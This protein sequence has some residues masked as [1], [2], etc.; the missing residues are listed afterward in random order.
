[1]KFLLGV[2]VLSIIPFAAV[3]QSTPISDRV[4]VYVNRLMRDI[5]ESYYAFDT[6]DSGFNHAIPSGLFASRTSLLKEGFIVGA[7]VFDSNAADGCS[8]SP[9]AFDKGGAMLKL[10]VP[11]LPQV[12]DY[13]GLNFEEPEN[14]GVK[15]RGLGVDLTGSD[16]VTLQV[17]GVSSG[18]QVKFG[19]RGSESPFMTLS[20]SPTDLSFAFPTF[21]PPLRRL[22]GV[23]ILFTVATDNQHCAKGGTVLVRKIRFTPA[24][25]STNN[26][27]GFPLANET[28]GINPL[29]LADCGL[30]KDK[31]GNNL[32]IGPD[33][34]NR[35]LTTIYESALVLM[36][37]I[38]HGD[39]V[40][41]KLLADAFVRTV[42]T[43]S[44]RVL[45]VRPGVAGDPSGVFLNSGYSSGQLGLDDDLYQPVLGGTD[46]IVASRGDSALA[47]FGVGPNGAGGSNYCLV[48]DGG[49]GG[50]NAFAM[51]ALIKASRAFESGPEGPYLSAAR[52]IALWMDQNLKAP[53]SPDYDA[54]VDGASQTK[55]RGGFYLGWNDGG[56]DLDGYKNSTFLY[57]KSIENNADLYAAMQA[58]AFRE[59]ETGDRF[60]LSN[61]WI[62]LS[63]WAGD[64][65]MRNSTQTGGVLHFYAGTVPCSQ[66][67]DPGIIPAPFTLSDKPDCEVVNAFDF[68]DSTTFVALAMAGSSEY[69]IDWRQ[70]VDWSRTH[71]AVKG[72][73]SYGRVTNGFDLVTPGVPPAINCDP[74]ICVER[75]LEAYP[76]GISWEFTGQMVVTLK[77]INQLY[78]SYFTADELNS[79]INAIGD[80]QLND[81]YTN[82]FG[83]VAA[84]LAV[85]NVTMTPSPISS[86]L[87][88]PFQCIATRT[89]LAATMW[90]AFAETGYNPLGR[91]LIKTP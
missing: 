43:P 1:M 56:S 91:P 78:P 87:K 89:G 88:T 24:P 30:L 37:L 4:Y 35:N 71:Q 57:G 38:E 19:V 10:K 68:L 52:S 58:L 27:L 53:L 60:Q 32:P 3:S 13:F 61:H 42:T 7:C 5:R 80:T 48:L 90:A 54:T 17:A 21:N 40:N 39:N 63:H 65:V 36:G 84:T 31:K 66:R 11:P 45:H 49:T 15:R 50:N 25:S 6:A 26:A 76:P 22:T 73:K 20:S 82:Q 70:P 8:T 69:P 75:D 16:S 77:L 46:R 12:A 2:G 85:D 79:Y 47:G 62:D 41:A 55:L 18:C 74:T 23:H 72:L 83:L 29:Q 14:Y 28:Y 86:C 64:F 44:A 51:L 67:V 34:V 9:D 59:S 33:Q 81:R